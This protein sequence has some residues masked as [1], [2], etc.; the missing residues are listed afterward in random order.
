MQVNIDL[1]DLRTVDKAIKQIEQ[2]QK[3][4]QTEL[5][6]EFLKRCAETV[7]DMANN[8]ISGLPYESEI[9]SGLQ[10]S[11]KTETTDD[12]KVVTLINEYDKAV[13]IE[14]GTGIVGSNDAHEMASESGY[15]YDV[16]NHGQ[17]GWRFTRHVD[18]GEPL[19]LPNG[20][21]TIKTLG[22]TGMW[23]DIRT[24]GAPATMFLY[25]AAMNFLED[26]VYERIWQRMAKDL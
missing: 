7:R 8:I 24:Q 16:K 4:I 13:Y 23:F 26:K 2:Y 18:D 12:G 17:K 15:K 9:I 19:D 14:F 22:H 3:R 6:P 1:L 21:Y 5:I 25:N 11:W 20:S 10:N